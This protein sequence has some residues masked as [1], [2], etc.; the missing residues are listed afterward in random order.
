MVGFLNAVLSTVRWG[1]AVLMEPN[2][3]RLGDE[4]HAGAFDSRGL[5]W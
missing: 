3:I 1:V 4:I 2:L 5:A